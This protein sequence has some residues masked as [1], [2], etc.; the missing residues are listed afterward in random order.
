MTI[1]N[2]ILIVVDPTSAEQ[3]AVE[4]GFALAR[5]LRC[6]VELFICH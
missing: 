5:Q 6:P 2:R 4:R 1:D 3:P